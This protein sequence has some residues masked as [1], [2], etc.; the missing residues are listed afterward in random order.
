MIRLRGLITDALANANWPHRDDDP[1]SVIVNFVAVALAFPGMTTQG[2]SVK[3][4]LEFMK[5]PFRD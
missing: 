3:E 1:P 4:L 2:L 5:I